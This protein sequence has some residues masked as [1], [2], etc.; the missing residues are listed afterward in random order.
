M[1]TDDQI[2]IGSHK[3]EKAAAGESRAVPVYTFRVTPAADK[4]EIKK[5]IIKRYQIKPAKVRIVRIPS[6]RL[7]YRGRP[8]VKSG[9]KKAL[10]YLR[11]GEKIDLK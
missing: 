10:V 4:I 8:A 11:P 9:Y 2:I 1:K 3:T 7:I 5:A 6:K